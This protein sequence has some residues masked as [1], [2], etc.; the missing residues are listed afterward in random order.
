VSTAPVRI[1][2]YQ[3]PVCQTIY[4]DIEGEDFCNVCDCEN[5]DPRVEVRYCRRVT[6]TVEASPE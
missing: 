2:A 1:G 6:I 5:R 4:P 3:C